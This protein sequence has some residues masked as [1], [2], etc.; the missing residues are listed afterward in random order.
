VGTPTATTGA[1]GKA[2]ADAADGSLRAVQEI[3]AITTAASDN[4]ARRICLRVL[5]RIEA[6]I[7]EWNAFATD[8]AGAYLD[9]VSVVRAYIAATH[10]RLQRAEQRRQ[11]AADAPAGRGDAS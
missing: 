1:A 2:N 3:I 10:D 6:R 8:A 9:D 5:R 11:Q 4:T 7:P